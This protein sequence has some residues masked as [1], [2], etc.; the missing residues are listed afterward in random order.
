MTT[1]LCV[2]VYLHCLLKQSPCKYG[3]T[4]LRTHAFM[5]FTDTLKLVNTLYLDLGQHIET[6]TIIR[7]ACHIIPCGLFAVSGHAPTH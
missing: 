1:K 2:C 4:V 3:H 7:T 6:N 5:C